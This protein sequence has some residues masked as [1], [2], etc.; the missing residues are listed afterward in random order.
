MLTPKTVP[1]K[2]TRHSSTIRPVSGRGALD[3]LRIV[4]S[5]LMAP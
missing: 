3:G 4:V 5:R 1:K 2:A